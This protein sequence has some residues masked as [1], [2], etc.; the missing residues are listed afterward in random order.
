MRELFKCFSAAF[1]ISHK[2]MKFIYIVIAYGKKKLIKIF[3]YH[4]PH[5]TFSEIVPMKVFR[6][7]VLK[8]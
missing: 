1:K 4:I 2:H 5:S 3:D 8:I 6:S 7:S